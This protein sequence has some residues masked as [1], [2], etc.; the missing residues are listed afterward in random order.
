MKKFIIILL[1]VVL[2]SGCVSGAIKEK[3]SSNAAKLDRYVE[4][5][6][7]DNTTHEE[8]RDLIRAMRI[9]T[10]SMN[11]AANDE[12]PPPDVRFILENAEEIKNE[13]DE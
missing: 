12:T 3:L 9:W 5:M 10:W 7:E 13:T 2:L 4:L 8:D 11:W 1:S 6:D